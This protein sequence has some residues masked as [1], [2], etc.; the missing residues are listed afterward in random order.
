MAILLNVV[1]AL[2]QSIPKL[3]C[4]VTRTRDNLSVVST[5]T[6]GQDIGGVADESAGRCA[7]VKVP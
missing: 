1:F 5:E 3:N 7:S 2:S 6:D 4:L